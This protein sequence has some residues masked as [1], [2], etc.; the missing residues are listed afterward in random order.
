MQENK[1][2]IKKQEL[3][4]LIKQEIETHRMCIKGTR[5]FQTELRITRQDY[6]ALL[7]ELEEEGTITIGTY[8]DDGIRRRKID[9]R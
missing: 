4:V 7:D 8:W 5:F 9:I 2:E 1:K 3:L 6:F